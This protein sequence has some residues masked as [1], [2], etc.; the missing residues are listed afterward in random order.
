M[1][2]QMKVSVKLGKDGD[3]CTIELTRK[4]I[5]DMNAATSTHAKHQVG[6]DVASK[7]LGKR[8]TAKQ[9]GQLVRQQI[10]ASQV[11]RGLAVA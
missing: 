5:D 1:A 8:I 3:I 7:Q 6:A 9:Y 2:K 10:P 4:H 11:I